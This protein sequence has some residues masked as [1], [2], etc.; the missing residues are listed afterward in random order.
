MKLTGCAAV[1]GALALVTAMPAARAQDP[2]APPPE[3][4]TAPTDTPISPGPAP[5]APPPASSK[6]RTGTAEEEDDDDEVTRSAEDV[7]WGIGARSRY[8]TTP[9]FMLDVFVEHSTPMN[10]FSVAGEVIRRKGHFDIVLSIEYARVS[11]EDGLWQEKGENPG[12]IDMYP[13]LLKFDVALLSGDVSFIWHLPITD[14]LSFRYGA[15]IGIGVPLGSFTQQD[16]VCSS[17]TTV[18]DL[19]DPNACTPV[20]GKIED[21]DLPPI[22]PI[23]NVL[24][25]ARF[26][27]VDQ[28]SLQIEGGWRFPS[29]FIGGGVGYFF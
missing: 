8:I 2:P 3:P 23:V 6:L 15:G 19:D 29:F 18:D 10:S 20:P 25:G 14:F 21:G 28:L 5:G 24:L 27:L 4:A 16:T 1:V 11:P 12:M 17:N 7:Q 22:V 26:K 9:Q 13:D